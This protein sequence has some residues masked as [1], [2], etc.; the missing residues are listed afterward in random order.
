MLDAHST[1]T[2]KGVT[3]NQIELMNY[4]ISPQNGEV[5]KFCP[6]S[7]IETY[8]EGLIKRLHGIKVSVNESK[9]YSVYGHVCG[10][11]SINSTN[12]VGNKVP[13]ILQETNHNLYM[14]SNMT[15]NLEA[16]NTLRPA[17][18]EAL[19]EMMKRV[20]QT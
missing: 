20:H 18:A 19:Y 9:Y 16:I 5:V 14:N 13:A 1:I 12:R 10:K 3:D 11:H 4:Q 7:F 17:F 2:A 8:A 6:D 15:P